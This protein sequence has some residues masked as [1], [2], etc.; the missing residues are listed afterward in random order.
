MDQIVRHWFGE[1]SWIG[2]LR[3]RWARWSR[4]RRTRAALARLTPDLAAD[5]G[6]SMGEV[7]A[8]A[9]RPFWLD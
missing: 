7:R 3:R 2:N 8:E 4:N 9:R 1:L 5:I 6:R